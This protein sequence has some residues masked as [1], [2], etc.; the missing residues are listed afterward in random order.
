MYVRFNVRVVIIVHAKYVLES[1]PT[2]SV[3][4]D[5]GKAIG[6]NYSFEAKKRV[7]RDRGTVDEFSPGNF[8]SPGS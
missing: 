8:Q 1:V 4:R 5:H 2:N 6:V 3:F 7:G